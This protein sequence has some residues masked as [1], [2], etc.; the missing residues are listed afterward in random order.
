MLVQYIETSRYSILTTSIYAHC[1]ANRRQQ[2]AAYNKNRPPFTQHDWRVNKIVDDRRDN[3]AQ[4]FCVYL[5]AIFIFHSSFYHKYRKKKNI[6]LKIEVANNQQ[7]N[8]YM[9]NF[10]LVSVS[11][12]LCVFPTTRRLS[13]CFTIIQLW[14]L[15]LVT[16][17]NSGAKQ[18][19]S[20]YQQ[21]KKSTKTA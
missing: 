20:N 12:S 18:I 10:P 6:N 16:S 13:L 2:Q 14:L 17:G 21:T 9:I 3:R 11:V 1:I 19:H 5:P 7:Q 8:N 4:R 15:C